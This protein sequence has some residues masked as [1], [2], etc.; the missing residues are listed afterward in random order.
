MLRM[1][2]EGQ[3]QRVSAFALVFIFGLSATILVTAPNYTTERQGRFKEGLCAVLGTAALRSGI[4]KNSN[5]VI[6]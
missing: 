3:S 2:H 5:Q 6:P 1:I 4:K